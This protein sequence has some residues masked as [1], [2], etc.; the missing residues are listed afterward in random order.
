MKVCTK[1]GKFTIEIICLM[2]STNSQIIYREISTRNSNR[3]F[4]YLI[5]FYVRFKISLV[6]LCSSL[7]ILQSLRPHLPTGH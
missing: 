3:F 5:I 6:F 7:F 2:S 4:I 1:I